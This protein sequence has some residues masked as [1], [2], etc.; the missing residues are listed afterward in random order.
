[1]EPESKRIRKSSIV[2]PDGN[3]N[4]DCIDHLESLREEDIKYPIN[5]RL[6]HENLNEGF[7]LELWKTFEY[8]TDKGCPK[9]KLKLF[10]SRRPDVQTLN[11]KSVITAALCADRIHSLVVADEP[12]CCARRKDWHLE[13]CF[14]NVASLNLETLELSEMLLTEGTLQL[15]SRYLTN[16][17]RILHLRLVQCPIESIGT[18]RAM[19]AFALLAAGFAA[20]TTLE[21]IMI[22]I[23]YNR[24][25]DGGAILLR[26]LISHPKL[27]S[28]ELWNFHL[29]TEMLEALHRI[30]AVASTTRTGTR[31]FKHLSLA[32]CR[33]FDMESFLTLLRPI[34]TACA[35]NTTTQSPY[36]FP[37]KSLELVYNTLKSADANLLLRTLLKSG[38]CCPN[39]ERVSLVGNYIYDWSE[40]T[41]DLLRTRM[42]QEQH[43]GKDANTVCFPCPLQTLDLTHYDLRVPCTPMRMKSLEALK[44]ISEL[45]DAFPRLGSLGEYISFPLDFHLGSS[46]DA[47][48]AHQLNL[49]RFLGVAFP[50]RRA[51]EDREIPLSLWPLLLAKPPLWQP[52]SVIFKVL[53]EYGADLVRGPHK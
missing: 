7:L 12:L 46:S 26:G 24:S 34:N 11:W 5:I 40:L 36:C 33:A 20:N 53:Q 4:L 23:S 51:Q 43:N 8:Y 49:R 35:P 30:F 10:L 19:P 2:D 18:P 28:L 1:M 15:I 50:S 14:Q 21:S 9:W 52:A 16:G 25:K 22:N 45:M 48:V 13:D 17:S 38:Q 44:C 37:L 29:G 41:K 42:D 6:R 3:C 27:Q 31:H 32:G 47:T 39:L